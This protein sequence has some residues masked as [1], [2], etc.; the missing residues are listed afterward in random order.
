MK[1]IEHLSA[2]EVIT[3]SDCAVHH[4]L[5]RCKNRARAI[6]LSFRKYPINDIAKIHE[7]DRDTVARWIDAWQR[8]GLIGLYDD[9]RTG[10]PNKLTL[11][12]RKEVIEMVKEEPRSTKSI[13]D[14]IKEKFGK[15]VSSRTVK[16]VLKKGKFIFK[17]IRL[18]LKAKRDPNLFEQAKTEIAALNARQE[19]GE[20]D[21]YFMDE[22]GFNLTPSVPYAWQPIGQRIEVISARSQNINVLGFLQANVN[23]ESYAFNE[24]INSDVV[25]ACINDF[26]ANIK[27]PTYLILDNS[28]IHTSDIFTEQIPIWAEK[29]LF[30]YRLPPYSPELNLIEIIWKFMK[31]KWLKFSAYLNFKTLTN[32]V[33]EILANIGKKYLITF[34]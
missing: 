6:L 32:A 20:I 1:F 34:G 8:V 30:V 28:P 26:S 25:I 33:D 15:I 18:S 11:D 9:S 16:R 31:Y 14:K 23:F 22:V 17:R 21:V 7:V 29:K 5:S 19:H 12:E 24:T 2:E 3:L 10:R 27:K 4:P 13:P